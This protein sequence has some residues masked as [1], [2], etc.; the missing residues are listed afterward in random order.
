MVRVRADVLK[1][2]LGNV[3]GKAGLSEKDATTVADHLLFCNLRGIDSHGVTRTSDY[4]KRLAD[5]GT[6]AHP[7]I[8]AI[9]R[10]RSAVL[11]DGD[12]GMGQVV[13]VYAAELAIKKAKKTGMCVVG[14]RGSSH[15]GAASYYS[16]R[17][18]ESGMVGFSTTNVNPI[19]P[20]WGGSSRAIGNNP[21]SIAVPGP[22][23]KSI[24][25]DIAM[26]IVAGGKIKLAKDS[27]EKIPLGWVLDKDGRDSDDPAAFFNGGAVL[28]FGGHKGYGLAFMLEMLAGVLVGAAVMDEIPVWF[29]ETKAPVNIGHLFGA[30]DIERFAGA[31]VFR[32]RL[33]G[34]IEELKERCSSDGVCRVC[35]PGEVEERIEA[36]RRKHGVPLSNELWNEL[37][38]ISMAFG[39]PLT[40]EGDQP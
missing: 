33:L 20:P 3:F 5:G 35:L 16:L 39:E 8:T 36:E 9:R 27:H 24:I 34:M 40:A 21:L 30:I 22:Q 25:L 29:K 10:R 17:I 1:R 11:L 2:F 37:K 4:L 38:K 32:E 7:K 31:D 13:G 18:A 28:P 12:Q 15:Y 6:N 26:S 23:G 19:M 14:V